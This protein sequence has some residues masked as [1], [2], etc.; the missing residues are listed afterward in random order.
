MSE[1]LQKSCREQRFLLDKGW[2][3]VARISADVQQQFSVRIEPMEALSS[4]QQQ[5]HARIGQ[6]MDQVVR[7][8]GRALTKLSK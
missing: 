5:R 7:D 4:E 1:N 8:Y 6:V 2:L 3:D